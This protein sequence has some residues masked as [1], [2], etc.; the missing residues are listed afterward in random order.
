MGIWREGAGGSPQIHGRVPERPLRGSSLPHGLR[1]WSAST[2]NW[3]F[4]GGLHQTCLCSTAMDG[5][6][7]RTPQELHS[8]RTLCFGTSQR[9]KVS[10]LN[11]FSVFKICLQNEKEQSRASCLWQIPGYLQVG[12]CF[13]LQTQLY[14]NSLHCCNP[15]LLALAVC[16]FR[17]RGLYSYK[18]ATSGGE[19]WK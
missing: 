13:C 8:F 12:S 15:A 11:Y 5:N 4:Q 3:C 9:L 19:S 17:L 14:W 7:A 18:Y 10:T 1:A 2:G 16:S 6:T